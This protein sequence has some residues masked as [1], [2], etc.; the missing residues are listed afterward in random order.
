MY[1]FS[2]E[3]TCFVLLSLSSSIQ[4]TNQ[5]DFSFL[6]SQIPTTEV[7]TCPDYDFVDMTSAF[8]LFAGLIINYHQLLYRLIGVTVPESNERDVFQEETGLDLSDAEIGYLQLQFPD[9]AKL[10][11]QRQFKA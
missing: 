11:R 4:F 5:T 2:L 9:T 10:V 3:I 8:S 7:T 6:L 1:L